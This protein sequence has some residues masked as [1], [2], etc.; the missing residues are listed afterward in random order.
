MP[1]FIQIFMIV[2]I[3]KF[4][5]IAAPIFKTNKQ[6]KTSLLLVAAYF[7][8]PFMIQFCKRAV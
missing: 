5:Q 6:T 1:V 8:T 7:S 2:S 4:L 3:L